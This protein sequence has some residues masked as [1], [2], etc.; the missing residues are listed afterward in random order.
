MRTYSELLACSSFVDKYEYLRLDG[1]VAH[2][3]FG[4]DRYINQGFY[5]SQAWKE[6]RDFVINRDNGCDLGDPDRPIYGK[7]LVH[8][9]NPIR[10]VDLDDFNHDVL[11]PEY[12][13][14]V[15]HDTN[16]AIH[17]GD[18]EQLHLMP[19]ERLPGD[20]IPWR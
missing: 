5:R 13:I 2:A 10:P 14:T 4:G 20:T 6:V 11:D 1:E 12:L 15:S 7:V 8:H 9:M 18:Q 3:T 19:P 16:N 17:Y